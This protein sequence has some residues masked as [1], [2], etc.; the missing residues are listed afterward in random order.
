MRG[1]AADLCG[2]PDHAGIAQVGRSR[3][4]LGGSLGRSSG[5]AR[6]SA[7]RGGATRAGGR[8]SAWTPAPAWQAAW[9]AARATD[10]RAVRRRSSACRAGR[11]NQSMPR[12]E[13]VRSTRRSRISGEPK[14]VSRR[15]G[16]PAGHAFRCAERGAYGRRLEMRRCCGVRFT[17]RVGACRTAMS[18]EAQTDGTACQAGSGVAI[19]LHPP[20][21]A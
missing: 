6:G 18:D 11:S 15:E 13:A 3:R 14:G 9:G 17:R 2:Q 4:S 7:R 1:V 20:V 10:D 21:A 16:A 8:G 19:P 5:R 12:P